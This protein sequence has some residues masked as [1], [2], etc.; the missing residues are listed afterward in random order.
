MKRW[1]DFLCGSA[2]QVLAG[3]LAY[4]G[5]SAL[6]HGRVVGGNATWMVYFGGAVLLFGVGTYLVFRARQTKAGT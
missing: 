1:H 3:F 2:L 6:S 5:I 4:M